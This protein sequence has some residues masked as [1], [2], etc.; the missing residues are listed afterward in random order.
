MLKLKKHYPGCYRTETVHG[1]FGQIKRDGREWKAEI[2]SRSGDLERYAGIW[3][4]RKDAVD[5][6]EHIL[7]EG[8][9]FDEAED[10][11]HD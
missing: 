7:E 6:V 10:L 11:Y 2:R 1:R 5:E 3:G 9:S 4:T 8:I